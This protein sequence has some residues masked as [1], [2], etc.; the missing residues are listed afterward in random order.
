MGG[1]GR[2]CERLRARKQC[3]SLLLT[4]SLVPRLFPMEDIAHTSA[5]T[6]CAVAIIP[7]GEAGGTA[8]VPDG[9][10]VSKRQAVQG[11]FDVIS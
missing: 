9:A 5:H 2:E 4:P 7:R 8:G 3:V 11:A 1:A 6:I 10:A